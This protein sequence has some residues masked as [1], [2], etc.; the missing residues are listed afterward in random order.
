M[1]YTK[2]PN[3]CLNKI[4]LDPHRFCCVAPLPPPRLHSG[5]GVVTSLLLPQ[6]HS[7][8]RHHPANCCRSS[9]PARSSMQVGFYAN[10]GVL[11]SSCDHRVH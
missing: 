5:T 3:K 6:T 8:H 1:P 11:Y 7:V 4:K 10:K 2:V 9:I